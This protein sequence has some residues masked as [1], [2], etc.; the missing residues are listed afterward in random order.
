MRT[1][2]FGAL[3]I[4]LPAC[5]YNAS[6]PVSPAYDVYTN[7]EDKLAGRYA[8]YINGD[9]LNGKYKVQ[10]Y[11]CSAHAYTQDARDASSQSVVQT[12]QNLTED[13][14]VVDEP[15]TRSDLANR[16]FTAQLWLKVI[17]WTSA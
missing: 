11:V 15:L 7:Y 17:A 1:L 5:T 14:E 10:G 3:T 12:F 8:L 4:A 6:A 13:L 2:L 16:D 9:D